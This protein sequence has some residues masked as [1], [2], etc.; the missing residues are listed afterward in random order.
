[1][2]GVLLKRAVAMMGIEVIPSGHAEK[3]VSALGALL[4]IGA[5]FLVN[6]LLP[7]KASSVPIIASMGASAVLLYAAPGS[8]LTQPWPVVGGH[9]ISALIGVACHH[10]IDSPTLACIVAVPTAVV[11]MYYLHCTHPPGGATALLPIIGGPD[12]EALGYG[13]MLD[14]VLLDSLV[15]IGVAVLVNRLIP[16]RSYPI[17]GAAKPVSKG[18]PPDSTPILAEDLEYALRESKTYLDISDGELRQLHRLAQQ[19]AHD[20]NTLA[21]GG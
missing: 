5:I 2:V 6:Q 4:G 16:W 12:I 7:S 18:E 14:P 20:R 11:A 1:M 9:L 17:N 3:W 13:F 21:G 8:P 15:L 19:H 10:L